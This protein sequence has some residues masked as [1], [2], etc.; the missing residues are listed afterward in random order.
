MYAISKDTNP[1]SWAFE[2]TFDFYVY[3]GDKDKTSKILKSLSEKIKNRNRIFT[4]SFADIIVGSWCE[5][6]NYPVHVTVSVE[7]SAH[8]IFCGAK[9]SE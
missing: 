9:H 3:T 8:D 1:R 6:K 4:K 2:V 5:W 7:Q